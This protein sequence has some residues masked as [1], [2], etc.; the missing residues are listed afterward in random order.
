[1]ER[2]AIVTG[3]GKRVGREIAQALL[4]DGWQVIAHVHRPDDEVP[5]GAAKTVADLAQPDCAERIFAAAPS[6]APVR[7]LINNAAR[8]AWD[9]FGEFSPGQ[10]D[11]HMA[12]NVRAPA[13][14]IERFAAEQQGDEDSSVVNLLDSKLF[15]LNAD[16]LSY[17][18]SKQA[19]SGL[20]EL[21]ARALAPRR[22]RVNG[23]A[24][25]LMLRSTG[26][27]EE[28]FRAMHADNPLRRPVEP[29]DI[30]AA[31]RYLVSARCVTGEVLAIDSGQ[32]F[33][34]LERDVQFLG[35]A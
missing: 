18:L 15:A 8:F 7:L 2:T 5:A 27:S 29:A 14:L 25:G 20:T 21:A 30:I 23:I 6:L 31:I 1:M 33:L 35:D 17:T 12:V 22:I 32:R 10:F 24:P 9:G 13:L 11:A 19:L 26:Q 3:A 28:N 34:A 4:D 16:F